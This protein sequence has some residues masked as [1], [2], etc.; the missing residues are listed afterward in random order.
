MENYIHFP[1]SKKKSQKYFNVKYGF[2]RKNL[3]FLKQDIISLF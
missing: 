2:I 3:R 1:K